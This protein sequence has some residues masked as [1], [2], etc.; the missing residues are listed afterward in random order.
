[1][2]Y[3]RLLLLPFSV[4]YA[5]V[6][7]V[8]NFLFDKGLLLS[9]AYKIPLISVGNL[10]V[11]GTGK[12]PLTEHIIRLVKTSKHC[13][14]LSRGYGRKTKGVIIAGNNDSYSTIG[15]EPMQLK[16]KFGQLTV[17]V[18]EE[19]RKG[20]DA[21]LALPQPPE[22]VLLDD[23]F[24]H[25]Y[26]KPGFSILVMDYYRPVWKDFC[27]PAG[28]LREPVSGK[29]RSDIVVVNKCPAELS[30]SEAVLIGEKLKL[31]KDQHL[32][33]TSIGYKNPAPLMRENSG[34]DFFALLAETQE[35]LVVVA[36]IGN[37]APFFKVA[38]SFGKPVIT[39]RFGDHHDFSAADIEAIQGRGS[40]SSLILT[41]EKDAVRLAE[42]EELPADFA[43]RVWYLPIELEFLFEKKDDFDNL[44]KKYVG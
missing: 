12:T 23:A 35:P 34:R 2:R 11:G 42:T 9:Q 30:Q 40:N 7:M 27:L 32:F 14:V 33:F 39:M 3:L 5:M 24:Q 22:V 10:T 43:S 21:L 13:A 37:P 36:G 15:D 29:K 16:R 41:T 38:A 17:A 20:M 44:I 18:A 8:R 31:K 28:N 25:R 19:R 26:V 6:V 4:L 1:M